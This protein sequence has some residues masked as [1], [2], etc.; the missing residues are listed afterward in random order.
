MRDREPTIRSRELGDG[1]RLAMERAGLSGRDVAR[2]LAWSDSRVSRLLTG[3]R[4]AAEN[5]IASFLGVCGVVGE[6]RTRLLKLT[7]EMSVRSWFQ[8]FGP[9]LPIQV[10]TLV[11]LENK[12]IA[13]TQ[14]VTLM[15]PGL[16][17]T[18]AYARA[19]ITRNTNVP[20][21][22]VEERVAARIARRI[23]FSRDNPP[24]CTFLIHE[25]VLRL[26]AG[27]PEIMSDQ[28]HMMLRMSVRSNVA[29]RVV[30]A[31]FGVHA[32]MAGAYTLLESTEYKPVVY[33]EGETTG[34]F[35]EKPEEIAAYKSVTRELSAAAL[36]EG[37]S[38]ELIAGLAIDLYS[39]R[40]GG[41]DLE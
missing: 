6:E 21:T 30:P 26:Q 39:D 11:D 16:L 8:Q 22:E 19:L 10:R 40:E 4:G 31:A 3:K 9:H 20:A 33:L 36:D 29:I 28:L 27:S 17:Q 7:R 13:I 5:D 32:G 35:L 24:K 18:D 34:A 41:H 38:K 12:A 14:F 25:F 2:R 1:L 23:I 37:E 15:L